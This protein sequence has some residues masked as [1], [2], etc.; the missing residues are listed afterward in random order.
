[1]QIETDI[2]IWSRL[3]LF[4]FQSLELEMVFIRWEEILKLL[5]FNQ[6]FFSRGIV[7]ILEFVDLKKKFF[8][9]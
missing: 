9:Y 7:K 2:F 6:H 1:M 3:F 5:N 4:H 8:Q